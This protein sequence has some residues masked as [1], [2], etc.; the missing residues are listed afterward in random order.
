MNSDGGILRLIEGYVRLRFGRSVTIERRG[1]DGDSYLGLTLRNIDTRAATI[2]VY[3]PG[4][5]VT[6]MSESF[7]YEAEEDGGVSAIDALELMVGRGMVERRGCF[8]IA[9]TVGDDPYPTTRVRGI[10]RW[11]AWSGE[12]KS[13]DEVADELKLRRV[14]KSSIRAVQITLRS[15]GSRNS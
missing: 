4:Q 6:L 8:W 1:G 14:E 3:G 10:T 13:A 7:L 12:L 5:E 9:T 11:P 2:N 15:H